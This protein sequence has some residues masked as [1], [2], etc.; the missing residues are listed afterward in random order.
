MR[1]TAHFYVRGKMALVEWGLCP[2]KAVT[3][4]GVWGQ[5][6]QHELTQRTNE[7]LGCIKSRIMSRLKRN[8]F[9]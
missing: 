5:S 4:E 9:T 8:D 1:N 3:L 7:I 6:I 2:G